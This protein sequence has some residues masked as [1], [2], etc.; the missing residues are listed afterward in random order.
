MI[1]QVSCMV[2]Y[3]MDSKT[4]SR[5]VEKIVP[6]QQFMESAEGREWRAARDKEIQTLRK[7]LNQ[8]DISRLDEVGLAQVLGALRANSMWP[9]IG[10]KIKM[11]LSENRIDTIRDSLRQLI[12]GSGPL[13]KRFDAFRESV[14]HIGPAMMTE[15][16]ALLQPETYIVWN[17]KMVTG[18]KQL[19]LIDEYPKRAK[20]PPQMTGADYEKCMRQIHVLLDLLRENGMPNADFLDLHFFLAYIERTARMSEAEDHD[21]I[22]SENEEYVSLTHD[23]IVDMIAS[24]GANLGFDVEQNRRVTTGAVVVYIGAP[25]SG[26]W[27]R[28]PMHLR[29][30]SPGLSTR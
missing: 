13:P 9:D 28:S 15:I 30:T 6:F 26:T 17:R 22:M 18:L 11:V 4:R 20:N 27:D 21:A 24:L 14:S 16:L 1:M 23:E 25:R 10:V 29:F 8:S 2:N 5:V 7:L 12:Y 3:M 19:G